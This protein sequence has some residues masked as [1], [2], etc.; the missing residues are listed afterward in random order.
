MCF[1]ACFEEKSVGIEYSVQFYQKIQTEQDSFPSSPQFRVQLDTQ[2]QMLVATWKVQHHPDSIH[3][4]HRKS[5]HWNLESRE[6]SAVHTLPEVSLQSCVDVDKDYHYQVEDGPNDAQHGQNALL[7]TFLVLDSLFFITVDSV[8]HFPWKILQFSSQASLEK[9]RKRFM[10]R[11]KEFIQATMMWFV[12]YFIW[13]KNIKFGVIRKKRQKAKLEVF[14]KNQRQTAKIKNRYIRGTVHVL[15]LRIKLE[16][17][18]FKEA[19]KDPLQ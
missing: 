4:Y 16:K 14:F 12:L 11:H 17:P 9:E 3:V 1:F 6:S 2:F 19:I 10:K 15:C 5:S 8:Y 18:G 7:L 13:L